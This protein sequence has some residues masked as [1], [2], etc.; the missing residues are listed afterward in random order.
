MSE[1]TSPAEGQRPYQVRLFDKSLKKQRKVRLLLNLLGPLRTERVLLRTNGDS[2]GGM[3]YHFRSAVAVI[4]ACALV[5][6]DEAAMA[7]AVGI[8]ARVVC[9]REGREVSPQPPRGPHV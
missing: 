9:H 8:P 4:G 1:R 5:V 7:S 3:N 2:R 6:R